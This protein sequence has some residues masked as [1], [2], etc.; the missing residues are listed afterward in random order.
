MGSCE[1]SARLI[2]M[3]L[4]ECCCCV[5]TGL[6]VRAFTMLENVQASD[7]SRYDTNCTVYDA[8]A[9]SPSIVQVCSAPT[10][11]PGRPHT[12]VAVV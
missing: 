7:P 5:T 11:V 1:T 8:S 3:P 6:A 2:Q 10:H 4:S 9:E 12:S